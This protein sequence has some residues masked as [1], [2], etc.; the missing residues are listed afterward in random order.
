MAK[1]GALRSLQILQLTPHLSEDDNVEQTSND[2]CF[3]LKVLCPLRGLHLG[4]T[5]SHAVFD[6][7]L[8]THGP[9]LRELSLDEP[10][11]F[12]SKNAYRLA[13]VCR[14]VH[15]LNIT[16]RRTGGDETEV[17]F[18]HALGH[19]RRLESAS[20]TFDCARP[21][22]TRLI[23]DG[24]ISSDQYNRET[25][26][27]FVQDALVKVAIDEDLA[28]SMFL[29]IAQTQKR[30]AEGMGLRHFML[31]RL[32]V[33]WP[34]CEIFGHEDEPPT[35]LSTLLDWLRGTWIC[36]S[37]IGLRDPDAVLDDKP[38]GQ[39]HKAVLA[40]EEMP[41]RKM[42]YEEELHERLDDFG[43]LV[44]N[45]WLGLWPCDRGDWKKSWKGR[46]LARSV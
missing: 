21:D 1:T 32:M 28:R 27:G 41:E 22:I 10:V 5:R 14:R 34:D 44:K 39:A 33:L 11:V 2:L 18:Y 9:H 38:G 46:P 6:T 36:E 12:T 40:R 8:E 45:A 30:R 29:A 16:I 3:I 15:N 20:I 7:L 43:P 42:D 24:D 26:I 4:R 17:A 35:N 19:F 31:R 25:R 23:N 13:E 37:S